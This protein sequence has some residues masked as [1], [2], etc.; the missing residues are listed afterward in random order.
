MI[1]PRMGTVFEHLHYK[2][3]LGVR[4]CVGNIMG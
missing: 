1:L 2:F 4:D 3:E